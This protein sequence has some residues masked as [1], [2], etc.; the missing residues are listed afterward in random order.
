MS[1]RKNKALRKLAAAASKTGGRMLVEKKQMNKKGQ[2][3][4]STATNHEN[5]ARAKLQKL[6]QWK[7]AE[8]PGY[9]KDGVLYLHTELV[10]DLK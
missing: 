3:T 1:G 8:P 5:T 9:I 2:A 4:F 10:E 6:K 7:G